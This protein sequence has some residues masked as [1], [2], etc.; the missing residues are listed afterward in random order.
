LF[1]FDAYA[2]KSLG[3]IKSTK[4]NRLDAI[5]GTWHDLTSVIA[6]LSVGSHRESISRF[7]GERVR[8]F[9]HYEPALLRESGVRQAV[10]TLVNAFGSVLSPLGSLEALLTTTH[11][12]IIDQYRNV[13]YEH[14]S[15]RRSVAQNGSTDR[16]RS[17]RLL[18]LF[19]GYSHHHPCWVWWQMPFAPFIDER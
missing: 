2:I 13:G 3:C 12:L 18:H 11:D 7:I 5:K 1:K 9:N 10:I 19:V 4:G 16:D 17:C 6:R 8:P 15:D 14:N